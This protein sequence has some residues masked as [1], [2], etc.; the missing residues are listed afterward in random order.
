MYEDNYMTSKSLQKQRDFRKEEQDNWLGNKCF[1]NRHDITHSN[2][3]HCH[4]KDN[5]P[6]KRIQSL[7]DEEF[8]SIDWSDYVLLCRACHGHVHWCYNVLYMAWSEIEKDFIL[9]K[10]LKKK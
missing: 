9:N 1:F 2:Q 8:E 5:K 6:H 4:R 10:T 3:L 7:T